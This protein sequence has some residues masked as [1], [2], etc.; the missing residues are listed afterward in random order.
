MGG[1]NQLHHFGMQLGTVEKSGR[2]EEISQPAGGF[3]VKQQPYALHIPRLN[4]ANG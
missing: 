1:I 3:L 2:N 4:N